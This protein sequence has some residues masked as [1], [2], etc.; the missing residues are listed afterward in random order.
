MK[1]SLITSTRAPVLHFPIFPLPSLFYLRTLHRFS[2]CPFSSF[3]FL[4]YPTIHLP[5]G[6]CTSLHCPFCRSLY[7]FFPLILPY[8]ISTFPSSSSPVFQSFPFPTFSLSYL[9]LSLPVL[10]LPISFPTY[11]FPYLS[12][13]LPIS[14]PTYLFPF[15]SLSLP[16]S[17]PTYPI[18]TLPNPYLSPFLNIQFPSFPFYLSPFRTLLFLCC[19][20]SPFTFFLLFLQGSSSLFPLFLPVFPLFLPLFSPFLY[21]FSSYPLSL[22]L[23]IC[24]VFDLCPPPQWVLKNLVYIPV[25]TSKNQYFS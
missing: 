13:S 14:F 25:L 19:H 23:G 21:S 17:F 7:S 20:P 10:S 8:F 15:L 1:N 22:L 3:P 4:I 9:F 18:S 11:L 5:S 6:P 24:W 16:I 12:L 2:T